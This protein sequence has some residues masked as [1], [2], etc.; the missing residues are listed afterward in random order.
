MTVDPDR[1]LLGPRQRGGALPH[2]FE[3]AGGKLAGEQHRS[4]QLKETLFAITLAR[5]FPN[6]LLKILVSTSDHQKTSARRR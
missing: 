2:R 1:C 4:R 5:R 3:I 6:P